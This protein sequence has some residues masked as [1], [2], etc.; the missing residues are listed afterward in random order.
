[1]K[2]QDEIHGMKYSYMNTISGEKL[3]HVCRGGLFGGHKEV[4]HE[5]NSMY[6]SLVSQTLAQNE[7]GTEE[8]YFHNDELFTT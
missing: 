4:I 8:K 6:Y 3:L 2:S 1:M 7:M 5:A